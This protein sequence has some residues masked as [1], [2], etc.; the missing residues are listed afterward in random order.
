MRCVSEGQPAWAITSHLRSVHSSCEG[1]VGHLPLKKEVVC[2]E[3]SLMLG[4]GTY[5]AKISHSTFTMGAL[6]SLAIF[7]SI[8]T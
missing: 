1:E 5:R 2:V 4:L 6:V 8:H 7:P 3:Q